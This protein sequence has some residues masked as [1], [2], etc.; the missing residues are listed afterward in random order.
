M[1]VATSEKRWLKEPIRLTPKRPDR[2]TLLHISDLHF[3][4]E[5]RWDRP[6]FSLLLADIGQHRGDIDL[7]ICTGDMIDSSIADTFFG[8][9]CEVAIANAREFLMGVCWDSVVAP[10]TGLFVVPGNHDYR[11]KG[12]IESLWIKALFPN[13]FDSYFRSALLPDLNV[14]I[15]SFD[16]NG[17]DPRPNLAT[18]VVEQQEFEGLVRWLQADPIRGH[19]SFRQVTRIALL[20]HHPMPIAETESRAVA[21]AIEFTILKNAANFMRVAIQSEIDLILHGHQHFVGYSRASFPTPSSNRELAVIAAG[22]AGQPYNGIHSY[23]VVTIPR[24]GPISVEQKI[25]NLGIYETS[26][27]FQV[28]THYSDWRRTRAMQLA[29]DTRIATRAQT[30]TS[31]IEIDA[32]GDSKMLTLLG[33][34]TA[35]DQPVSQIPMASSSSVAIFENPT[36]RCLNEPGQSLDLV[37]IQPGSNNYEMRFDPKLAGRPLDI[38]VRRE[39]FNSFFFDRQDRL[40]VTGKEA[41]EHISAGVT[42]P[43]DLMRITVL[44]L[45]TH[46]ILSPRVRVE[47]QSGALIETE[48]EYCES[49]LSYNESRRTAHLTVDYPLPGYVYSIV[50]DLPSR[51]DD[52][53]R[54]EEK[55][56]IETIEGTLAECRTNGATHARLSKTLFDFKTEIESQFCSGSAAP[57][58]ELA[59]MYFDPQERLLRIGVSLFAAAHPIQSWSLRKGVGIEGQALR[60]R[61]AIFDFEG[62]QIWRHYHQEP[63][64]LPGEKGKDSF[65]FAIP[66]TYPINSDRVTCVFRI[67]SKS[68]TSRL[69]RLQGD[70]PKQEALARAAVSHYI[71]RVLP[72]VGLRSPYALL[73]ESNQLTH[74]EAED[75]LK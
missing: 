60:R 1:N 35:K 22:S 12:L 72:E 13:Y 52:D 61:A 68:G 4:A 55:R 64:I 66:L 75:L 9:S 30:Y 48:S 51:P 53:I 32:F 33:G 26:R 69:L 63:P 24:T 73:D 58:L 38:E 57:D 39:A 19:P 44:F 15:A 62:S 50:W 65:V 10:E 5:S 49:R 71:R 67:A 43:Y 16:S 14:L 31:E 70:T 54:A 6:P 41:T 2:T 8:N 59:L 3:T 40:D 74:A 42:R 45:S 46:V 34:L 11:I 47:D 7:V 21:E 27:R 56:A 17:T 37:K 23:N 29:S 36:C 25:L 18:G 20:H 28:P